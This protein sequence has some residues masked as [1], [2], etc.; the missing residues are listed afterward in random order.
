M[1]TRNSEGDSARAS[2]SGDDDGSAGPCSGAT[3]AMGCAGIEVHR[4]ASLKCVLLTPDLYGQSAAEH[5]DELSAL[6]PVKPHFFRRDRQE[7]HVI[8]VQPALDRRVVQRL[9]LVGLVA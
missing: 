9:E 6:V 3:I 8:A 4:V 1:L 2:R 5:E 7:F